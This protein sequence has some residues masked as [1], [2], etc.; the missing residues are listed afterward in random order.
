M[1]KWTKEK[2]TEIGW[3]WRM[4]CRPESISVSGIEIEIVFVG[5]CCGKLM[6]SNWGLPEGYEWAG[7]I[8]EPQR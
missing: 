3:Y 1:L 5:L 2:P 6:I 7:P 4:D 8:P